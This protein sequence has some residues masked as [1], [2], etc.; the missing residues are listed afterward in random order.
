MRSLFLF[1]LSLL[2]VGCNFADETD[3][4]GDYAIDK[5]VLARNLDPSDNY[6]MLRLEP[7]GSFA[8][9]HQGG[10]VPR[11]GTWEVLES[12]YAPDSGNDPELYAILKF[13]HSGTITSAEL[14]GTVIYFNNPEGEPFN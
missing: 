1:L 7:D 11:K 12:G 14:R 5:S 3:F 4:A 2:I 6:S 13:H 8:L 10:S 9:L